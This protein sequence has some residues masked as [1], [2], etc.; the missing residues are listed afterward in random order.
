MNSNKRKMSGVAMVEFAIVAPLLILLLL[1]IIELGHA[2]YQHNTLTK[3]VAVGAR[4]MARGYGNLSSGCVKQGSWNSAEAVAKNLIIYGEV[5]AGTEGLLPNL[6]DSGKTTIT[7][8]PVGSSA[9]CVVNVNVTTD[10]SPIFG[11]LFDGINLPF[12]GDIQF[13]DFDLV[14][15][16][17]ERYIGE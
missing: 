13:L 6:N 2:F 5:T 9:P 14:A 7:I 11:Y 10:Y 16:S 4:Y 3:S 1:G 15:A 12:I 8:D 17:Q